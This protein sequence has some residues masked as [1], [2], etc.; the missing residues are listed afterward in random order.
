MFTPE[1]PIKPG[2]TFQIGFE[3]TAVFP[4]G[5]TKKGGGTNEFILPSGVVLTSFGT[6]FLP[7]LGF[8][9][10]VGVDEENRYES[11]EY[12]DDYYKGQTDSFAGSRRPFKTKV[13][14]TGPSEF[15]YNSVGL[16][17]RDE[18]KN[19]K[20]TTVWESDQ[21]VNF[22]NIVAGKW[23]VK[24]GEGTAVYYNR[25]HAYN[26]D[27]M[28]EGLNAAR[29]Y[30]SEW[31]FPFPWKELKLS[32]FPALASYAQGFPTDITFSESIGFLTKSDPGA[33]SAFMVTAHEAAHQWWGNIIS[34]GKG[35][36]GNLL[37]EGSSHFSTMLLFE[38]VKGLYPRIEFAKKIED[39]Y[40]KTRS[41]D[42]ERPL[43]KID[44][45]R[46]GDQTVIYDK[47]GWVLWMLM[48]E[49]GR[50]PMLAGI[51]EF[52][53]EYRDNPDHPVLQDFLAVLRKHAENPEA[54]DEFTQQWFFK[55]VVPEYQISDAK[56][57]QEGKTWIV[58]AK[59]AN[60]GTGRMPVEFAAAAG[61]RF[62]KEGNRALSKDYREAR[63]TITLG[64]DENKEITITCDFKPEQITADPDAK[65]LQLR[66]K[67]AVSKF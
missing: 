67:A 11:R 61:E 24:R 20:R 3:H 47:T 22:F 59:V 13:T 46:D 42:S 53:K 8:F 14:I 10:S 28:I 31:F 33:N 60:I 55:V 16:Q 50:D 9:E 30:Y 35:P 57:T 63:T 15:T 43:V 18:V 36:G 58:K 52:F 39:S 64:G 65:V 5:I 12:P 6:S 2:G 38:Q 32:E 25:K 27:E 56:L 1:T 37:S 44:G 34:P 40:A 26:V 54:F 48:Q 21:P 49:M 62:E 17:T 4:K 41:T 29:K 66:R 45:S 19:G 23:E 51:K 7:N